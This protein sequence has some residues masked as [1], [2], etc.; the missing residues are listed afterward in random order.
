MPARVSADDRFAIF[1]LFA[2][3][4]RAL[5][6]GD[7]DSYADHFTPDALLAIGEERFQGR[8]FIREYVKRLTSAPTWRGY[9]H[10]NSQILIESG[11]GDRCTV[12]C[13]S[14]ITYRY[15]DGHLRMMQQ[16]V[17]RD[18]LVKTNGLWYFAQRIWEPWDP[19]KVEEYRP[20]AR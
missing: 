4:S 10:H 12:S 5:D 15:R 18:I 14:S 17:Y 1:E 19:D 11:D 20:P 6:T 7:Y 3:Y 9:Q 16:G 8:E 13:Y 2:R